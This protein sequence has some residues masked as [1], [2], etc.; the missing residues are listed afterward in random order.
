MLTAVITI[1]VI[2]FAPDVIIITW[3]MTPFT[4]LGPMR[5]GKEIETFRFGH[6]ESK[7]LLTHTMEF[8]NCVCG[9]G[10]TAEQ[11]GLEM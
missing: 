5:G 2:I 1:L 3:K 10:A 4:E 7:V 11:S 6:A 9:P 8:S